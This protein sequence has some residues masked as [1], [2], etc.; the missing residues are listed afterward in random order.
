MFSYVTGLMTDAGWEHPAE[1]VGHL[2]GEF[3]H[4]R[5][6]GDQLESY[7]TPANVHSLRRTDAAGRDCHWIL[8]VHLVDRQ[9]GFGGFYEQLLDV[10]PT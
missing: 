2:V 3:P 8:E 7:L 9:R 10:P 4:E 1:H 6:A 5:I